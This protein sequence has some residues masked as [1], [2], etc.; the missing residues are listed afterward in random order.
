MENKSLPRDTSCFICGKDNPIGLKLHFHRLD[1]L[2]VSAKIN[3]H[4]HF[5]GF[6]GTAHGG[7]ISA[8]LDDAMDWALYNSTGK[9]YV[10]SQLTV[11][12]KKPV[13]I[14]TDL[15]VIAY[16]V[17][18]LDGRIR[19]IEYARAEI[20]SNGEILA[21]AEGKFFQVAQSHEKELLKSFTC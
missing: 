14:D 1:E 13:P 9:L 19:K 20:N 12:F 21:I 7:I 11:N 16:S 6:K 17:K 18:H 4:T 15:E 2:R 8:M 3:L 10:T 5:A